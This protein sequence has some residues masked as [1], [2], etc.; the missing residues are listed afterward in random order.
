MDLKNRI[1]WED[2]LVFYS[3]VILMY[4]GAVYIYSLT[5]PISL[6]SKLIGHKTIS[7]FDIWSLQHFLSGIILGR[8]ICYLAW[9]SSGS[10]QTV[11]VYLAFLFCIFWWEFA[12]TGMEV[13]K[14]SKNVIIWK[15][16]LESFTNRFIGDPMMMILGLYIYRRYRKYFWRALAVATFWLVLNL[17]M[18]NCMFIQEYITTLF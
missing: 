3:L 17:F 7:V 1:L 13:G 5:Y 12:E 15:D 9:D 2:K 11:R 10:P 18:P 8:I 6:P 14:F 16:G 4:L